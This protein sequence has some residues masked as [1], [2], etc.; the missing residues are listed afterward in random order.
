[1][2]GADPLVTPLGG[3]SAID[4][5]TNLAHLAQVR[6]EQD[7]GALVAGELTSAALPA[8]LHEGTHHLCFFSPV[9]LTLALLNMRARRRALLIAFQTRPVPLEASPRPDSIDVLDD[10]VRQD[11]VTRALRPLAEG[12]ATFAEFDALPGTSPIS[13]EL[14]TM[15]LGH[16]IR[17]ADPSANPW[18]TLAST[19]RHERSA[20]PYAH[21]KA[22]LLA[23]SMDPLQGGYL[24]GYLFVKR[25]WH[26]AASIDS[27]LDDTDLFLSLLV[28][29]VYNDFGLVAHLLDSGTSDAG[30][31]TAILRHLH[32]RV[33]K[34]IGSM[35]AD[36]V[37][38]VE[39][40]H[41]QPFLDQR[42]HGDLMSTM[43]QIPS[44]GTDP[45]LA[46]AGRERLAALYAELEREAGDDAGPLGGLPSRQLWAV[47]QR[48]L[49]LLG[50][51]AV[52]VDVNERG[53]V[54]VWR[55]S[56]LLTS[57]PG[58]DGVQQC[59]RTPGSLAIF[60]NPWRWGRFMAF[61]ASVDGHP[62]LVWFSRDVSAV[63][64]E[65]FLQFLTDPVLAATADRA[66]AVV[67]EAH[68][69]QDE[70]AQIVLAAVRDQLEHWSRQLYSMTALAFVE[71]GALDATVD[72]MTPDGLLPIL[73]SLP[74]L[75]ALAW[76][77]LNWMLHDDP[78]ELAGAFREAEVFHGAG[79]ELWPVVEEIV[80]RAQAALGEPLLIRGA[81]FV[82][83]TV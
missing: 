54:R 77:S 19:L 5:T 8:F 37:D 65:Q 34:L 33:V 81:R 38:E 32:D 75:R 15:L 47:A 74:H 61:T 25:L 31:A 43:Q 55:G 4:P 64:K 2:T 51:L 67:V 79:P 46:E 70:T 50:A 76:L 27:R 42:P 68:L 59:A 48:Q 6:L 13:T 83:C 57:G 14:M 39:A 60:V 18:D 20:L 66:Q 3:R 23:Q 58:I 40:G 35:T 11:A 56:E 49:L 29:Y 26:H 71:P 69:R 12:L 41:D 1:M 36:W 9:G 63:L 78:Q 10:Y 82:S 72:R 62:L 7:A 17:H 52:E 44:L 53:H 24:A 30:A 28:T 21:R 45:A 16:F 73:G 80:V 22:S